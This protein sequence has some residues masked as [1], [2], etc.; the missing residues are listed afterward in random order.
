[1]TAVITAL[2]GALALWFSA[3]AGASARS[4]EIGFGPGRAL[5]VRFLEPQAPFV[6]EENGAPAGLYVELLE[7]IARR[8]KLR[9]VIDINGDAAEGDSPPDLI[10]GS[11]YP[12]APHQ[13][14]YGYLPVRNFDT[15]D[16]RLDRSLTGMLSRIAEDQQEALSFAFPLMWESSSLFLP[17]GDNVGLENLR[18]KRICVVHGSPEE[19][20]L[21][22]FGFGGE[23]FRCANVGEGMRTLSLR[24]CDA[25]A[26]ETFAGFH[27]MRRERRYRYTI[28][29]RPL[30]LQSYERA[31]VVL[32]GNME[33]AIKIG[34]ALRGIKSSGRYSQ[35]LDRWLTG[36]DEYLL[37]PNFVLRAA[38]VAAVVLL[39]MIVWN[40]SL[41]RKIRVAVKERERI[42]DFVREGLLAVDASGR[43]TMINRIARRLLDLHGDVAG[44]DAD[45]LI[46]GLDVAR[47]IRSLEPEYNVE[48]NLRGALVSC[49]KAPVVI[50]GRAAGAIVTFHDLSELSAMAEEMTGVKMYVE[51]LRIRNHEFMNTLQAISGLI[52]LG[53][54]DKAVSYI[55]AETGASQ[56]AQSFMTERIKSAA[57]CGILMGKAGLCREQH[58]RFVLDPDSSCGDHGVAVGDRSLVII[59]GNLIQN[60]IEAILEQGVGE[61][62]CITFAMYDESGHIFISVR[63]TAGAMSDS[64]A[65]RVFD[66]GFSTRCKKAP[67]GFG[68]YN[69]RTIVESLGGDITVDYESGKYTEFAVTIPIPT[70]KKEAVAHV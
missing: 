68:L 21:R 18:G 19:A 37:T 58:I 50:D 42:F 14:I 33:L 27:E 40:H 67:S 7:A 10:V 46:P 54:Y 62:S 53:Q 47:Q 66:K 3:G 17:Q 20:F 26:C 24:I 36:A 69:I 60:A 41:G 61:D 1:L 32:R 28:R 9:F 2:F 8:A 43:V 48:Q 63:D 38:A 25:F 59:V 51:S 45:L 31:V 30:L 23:I 64:I 16:P 6:F 65:A 55:A 39:L 57:V 5:S 15:D 34:H 70:Q 12:V 52:Q 56:T 13:E 11:T 44:Q 49:N 22:S 29:P 4:F 35:I